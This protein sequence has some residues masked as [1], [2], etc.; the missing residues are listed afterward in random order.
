MVDE[1]QVN[2]LDKRILVLENKIGP[3]RLA[4][5]GVGLSALSV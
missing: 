1:N 3:R 4:I 2:P 5:S